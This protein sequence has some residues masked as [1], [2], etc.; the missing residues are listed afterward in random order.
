MKKKPVPVLILLILCAVGSIF[1]F[2]REKRNSLSLPGEIEGTI[3]PQ[4]AEVAGKIITM[5][6]EL[7]SHVNKGDLIA[8]IDGTDQEYMLEQ[9]QIALERR[10]LTL[11]NLLKGT[12]REELEKARSDI[13]I[14][15]ANFRSAEATYS[16]AQED[17]QSLEMMLE[18]GGVAQNEL[19][20]A[21]LRE[22]VAEEAL[23]AAG[24]QVQKAR[25]QLSLLQKGTDAE[26]IALAEVDIRDAQSRIRQLEDTLKKFEITANCGG[27]VISK[28]YGLGSIVNAGFNLADISADNEKYVIF[29]MPKDD[30]RQISFGQLLTVTSAGQEYQGTVRFIDVKSQYTPKDMQTSVTKNK[31][32]VKVKLLLPAEA[33]LK[34][35]DKVKVLVKK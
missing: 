33:K 22:T 26:I 21:R 9:L 18:I 11:T 29:Y 16:Q 1:Y 19:D 27:T 23:K 20:K 10:Q 31:V 8:R 25:E 2:G 5:D 13:R 34:P 14:A 3:Y 6:I 28:N 15:E 32:S 35:G 12:K 30:S 17:V 24:S 7:G 4:I